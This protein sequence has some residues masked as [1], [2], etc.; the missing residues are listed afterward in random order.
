MKMLIERIGDECQKEKMPPEIKVILLRLK[1]KMLA[2]LDLNMC[3][4][5]VISFLVDDLLDLGQLKAEKFRKTER[6]FKIKHPI[7]EIVNIL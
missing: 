4:E 6:N 2:S 3:G 7:D 1:A 5:K